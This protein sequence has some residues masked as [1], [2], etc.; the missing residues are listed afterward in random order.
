MSGLYVVLGIWFALNAAFPI[1]TLNRRHR[2]QLFHRLHRWVV[3]A[4]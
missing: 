4:P 3:V 2:A 1:A